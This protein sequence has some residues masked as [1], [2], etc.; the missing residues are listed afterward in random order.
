VR[1]GGWDADPGESAESRGVGSWVALADVGAVTVTKKPTTAVATVATVATLAKA[2]GAVT[3]VAVETLAV[4]VVL[5]NAVFSVVAAC[6]A[7]ALVEG[8][9]RR[10]GFFSC[11]LAGRQALDFD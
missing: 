6:V 4:V 1:E 3:T 10:H 7:C 8:W 9:P 2:V 11:A 5:A